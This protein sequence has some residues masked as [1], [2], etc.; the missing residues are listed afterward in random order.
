MR[1]ESQ[2]VRVVLGWDGGQARQTAT[3]SRLNRTEKP[4][5]VAAARLCVLVIWYWCV[6]VLGWKYAKFLLLTTV[7]LLFLSDWNTELNGG[8]CG[9]EWKWW[10]RGGM[11]PSWYTSMCTHMYTQCYSYYILTLQLYRIYVYQT[12]QENTHTHTNR[13]QNKNIPRHNM[14]D[15]QVSKYLF[16]TVQFQ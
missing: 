6:V 2:R 8:E 11:E 5:A 3:A 7:L 13:R 9:L 1:C 10:R 16:Y 4:V 12:P 15:I 14:K